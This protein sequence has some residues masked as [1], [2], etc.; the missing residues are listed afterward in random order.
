MRKFL[1]VGAVGRS[2][3]NKKGY[4]ARVLQANSI[5]LVGLGYLKA[6]LF[7]GYGGGGIQ[8]GI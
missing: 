1:Q 7:I 3:H 5:N 2:R 6:K 8:Y 4:A